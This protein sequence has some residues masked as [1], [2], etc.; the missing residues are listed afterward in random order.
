MNQ[1]I[2]IT[3]QGENQVVNARDL[4]QFL[5]V[6]TKFTMWIERRIEEYGFI[7]NEDFEVFPIFGKKSKRGRPSK[8]YAITLDMAKEL[9]MVERNEKG[10]QARR[11]FI[12]IEKEA[13]NAHQKVLNPAQARRKLQTELMNQ[14][15]SYL[16]RGDGTAVALEHGFSVDSVHNVSKG[17]TFRPDIV[18]ALFDKAMERKREMGIDIQ[19]MINVLNS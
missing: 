9:S 1:L 14:I 4:H 13:R 6:D 5:E 3:Q 18:K 12:A 19:S 10:R 17:R 16:L 15:K 2:T 7:E 11:Y 8:E